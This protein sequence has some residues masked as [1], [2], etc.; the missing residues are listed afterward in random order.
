M[1][2]SVFHVYLYFVYLHF[3]SKLVYSFLIFSYIWTFST[4]SHIALMCCKETKQPHKLPVTTKR[5]VDHSQTSHRTYAPH[6][7]FIAEEERPTRM[8]WLSDSSDCRARPLKLY[9]IPAET[10]QILYMYKPLRA[11]QLC[12]TMSNRWF[13][14]K[15][16][17][18]P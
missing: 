4:N 5:R 3:I 17:S 12:F 8:Q 7:W 16:R 14:Q 18:L 6:S 2:K 13:Q 11:G 15:D 9:R 1:V 10:R